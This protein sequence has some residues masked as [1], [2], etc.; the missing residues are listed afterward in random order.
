[1][2]KHLPVTQEHLLAVWEHLPVTWE[3][4]VVQGHLLATWEHLVSLVATAHTK[5]KQSKLLAKN[6]RYADLMYTSYHMSTE[7]TEFHLTATTASLLV[8]LP[9]PSP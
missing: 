2:H 8:L 4:L 9:P 7:F 1:M 5:R 3:Y 6:M